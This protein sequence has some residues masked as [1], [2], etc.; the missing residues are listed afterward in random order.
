MTRYLMCAIPPWSLYKILLLSRLLSNTPE[1]AE[2]RG[3]GHGNDKHQSTVN[4][5]LPIACICGHVV[6]YT[7]FR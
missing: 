1:A 5:C 6:D 2:L 4:L 3:G 7:Y